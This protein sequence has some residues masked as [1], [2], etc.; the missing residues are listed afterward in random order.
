MQSLACSLR[1]CERLP[2]LL[3]TPCSCT[4]HALSSGL[5][6]G[7]LP[8]PVKVMLFQDLICPE[9]L[10]SDIYEIQDTSG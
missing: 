8:P 3:I 7:H 10:L 1:N 9:E 5:L 6:R 2:W 4:A